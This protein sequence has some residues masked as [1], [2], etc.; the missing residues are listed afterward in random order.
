MIA[1]N[2]LPIRLAILCPV[3][4]DWESF[5]QLVVH[6][7]AKIERSLVQS[8]HVY[9][10]NDGSVQSISS[11][12]LS[13]RLSVSIIQLSRNVGHQKAI[14]IGASHLAHTENFDYLVVMDSD[15]EDSPE[16][17]N[18]LIQAA[19][20]QPGKIVFAQ[21]TKRQ[22]SLGFKLFYSIYKFIFQLLTGV[23]ISFGNFSILPFAQLVKI[24]HVSEIWNHF[25]GGAIRSKIPIA[26]IPTIR[27][28]RFV[29]TSKMNFTTLVLHGLSAVS[30]HIDLVAVRLLVASIGFIL[31]SILAILTVI[32]I[33]MFTV[34][35]IPGWTSFVVLGLIIVVMQAFLISLFLTFNILNLRSQ[36][37]FIPYFD[38]KDF[39]TQID[40][41][42]HVKQ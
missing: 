20:H 25:A 39:I 36:K 18:L 7:D 14:A 41:F 38:Y 22:E 15:G 9:A 24:T 2:T 35:A 28:K 3:Y 10:V 42:K 26:S 37:L 8:V 11:P 17:I 21:R 13:E 6:L 31:V 16:D 4:N 1:P 12:Y 23:H 33:K 34:L 5:Q 40:H 19:I 30:V 32:G 29:G 27:G